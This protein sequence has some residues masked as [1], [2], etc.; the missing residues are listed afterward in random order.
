MVARRKVANS[1]HALTGA[2]DLLPPE[3][4]ILC[5]PTLEHCRDSIP[6]LA[7]RLGTDLAHANAIYARGGANATPL[8]LPELLDVLVSY[9]D[10]EQG[11][12][13]A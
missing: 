12:Q 3:R 2:N 1:W 5:L 10:A 13:A 9:L 4:Q 8:A 11:K 7:A 6:S